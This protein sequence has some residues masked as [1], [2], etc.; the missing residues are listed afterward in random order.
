MY[1]WRF[2]I[3]E[4]TGEIHSYS[5][6]II[7]PTATDADFIWTNYHGGAQIKKDVAENNRNAFSGSYCKYVKIEY[8]GLANSKEQESK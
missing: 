6:P 4:N 2:Y 7:A 5:L 1:K 8:L 3:D